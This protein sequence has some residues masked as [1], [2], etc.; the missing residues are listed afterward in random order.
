M[1]LEQ[2][3]LQDFAVRYTVAWC[4][5]NPASVAAFYSPNGSLSINGG[6][7]SV[8][9]SAIAEAARG[10][11]MM[12]PDMRVRM[13][14]ILTEG[15]RVEYHWTLVGTNS[16]PGGTGRRVCISGFESWKFGDDRLI[17]ESRGTFDKDEFQRQLEIVVGGAGLR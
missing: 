16:G 11:M 17:A 1:S 10:F 5:Q 7:A 9:R 3:D 14:S 12:F 13:D 2:M 4:S 15:D 8:G 6:A